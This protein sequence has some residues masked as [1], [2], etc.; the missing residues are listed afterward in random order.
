MIRLAEIAHA[1]SGDKGNHANIGVIAWTTAGFTYLEREL[2]AEKVEAWFAPLSPRKVTRY[3]LPGVRAFNFVLEDV[4]GGG[5]S[6]SL[7]TDSQ[8]KVLALALLELLLPRPEN[9]ESLRR[10]ETANVAN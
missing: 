3:I 5:A 1:R 8:G 4:L 6:R 10:V 9:L 2:T 7:R